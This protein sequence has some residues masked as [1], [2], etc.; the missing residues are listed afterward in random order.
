V[1]PPFADSLD[2]LIERYSD[3]SELRA[4][5]SGELGVG[6]DAIHLVHRGRIL[7]DCFTLARYG[8]CD[9]S[10][11]Y[12][13][14]VRRAP[15]KLKPSELLEL[16]RTKLA[17]FAVDPKVALE[18]KDLMRN[19]VLQSLSQI[20][21]AAMQLFEDARAQLA[22]VE[23]RSAAGQTPISARLNDLAINKYELSIAGTKKLHTSLLK[24]KR[25][26][27]APPQCELNL[28]FEPMISSEPLPVWRD[29]RDD[30]TEFK[31]KLKPPAR[32]RFS[33]EIRVLK[34][35][36]FG[37]ESV[38]RKALE[39]TSG[40]VTRAAKLLRTQKI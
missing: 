7:Q 3:V 24:A 12:V 6:P 38:I 25:R 13:A 17:R 19:R 10:V 39:E 34:R 18:I 33:H 14:A 26:P 37:D 22:S 28:S 5:V 1:V 23:R 11:V 32:E 4:S 8:L 31:W 35:M 9:G 21:P 36:G 16:M 27:D 2:V 30:D 29:T 20:D 15:P 40:N